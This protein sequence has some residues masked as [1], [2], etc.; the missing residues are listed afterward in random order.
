MSSEIDQSTKIFHESW[1]RLARQKIALRNSIQ[2]HR[3]FYRGAKWYVLYNS[4]T[5]QY[6]RVQQSAYDFLIRLSLKK[7][8]EEVWYELLQVSPEDAPCQGEII[9][10]LAQLYHANMLH[11]DLAQDSIKLFERHTKKKQRLIKMTLM[12]ILFLRIPLFDP[13]PLLKKMIGFIGVVM[14]KAGAVL[15]LILAI[16]AGRYILGN[17]DA[18]QNQAEGVIAPNNLFLLYIGIVMTK[19]A[20]EFGHAFAVRKYGGEVHTM[21]IMFMLLIPLPYMDATASW[22]FRAKRQRIL[23]ALSGML[24]EFFIAFIAVIVWANVGDGTIK[25]V[26]YNMFFMASLTTLLFNINPLMR[27]DGYYILSD[28]LDMPN[29]HQQ[30]HAHLKYMLERYLFRKRGVSGPASDK[31]ESIILTIFGLLSSLYKFVIFG[32]IFITIS[33]QYLLLGF[34]MGASMF[35]T[36]I[37][38][39]VSKFIRYIYFSPDLLQVRKRAVWS[40]NLVFLVLVLFLGYLPVPDSFTAPGVVESQIKETTINKASGWVDARTVSSGEYV[41]QGDTLFVL[42]NLQVVNDLKVANAELS[43][44]RHEYQKAMEET[45]ENMMPIQKRIN[46][47]KQ[48]ISQLTEMKSNL[49]VRAGVSGVWVSPDFMEL[50]N[51][52]LP[53]GDSLGVVFDTTTIVFKAIIRQEEASRLFEDSFY[54]PRVKLKGRSDIDIKTTHIKTIPVERKDLPSAALG[55]AGGGDVEVNTASQGGTESVE[56]FYELILTLDKQKSSKSHVALLNGRSGLLRI[57]FQAKPIFQQA[58]R[59]IRQIIQKHYRI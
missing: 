5:N 38:I 48:N 4:F 17:F 6:Y 21:G 25:A 42:R 1:Y 2:I 50:E 31:R 18:I 8:V 37:L 33:Q 15:W 13:E 45:P 10:L 56:P 49:V 54:P 36:W 24:F 23:V 59:K 28:A 20:H 46:M 57:R 47:L 34:F 39:P 11:Y 53:R 7:T 35:V 9:D 41:Q 55:W 12:N 16:I 32:G 19:V 27:F 52:F 30:S 44:A 43:Q 3:Q 22:S 14:S 51:K 26:A 58:I 29:M 40:T